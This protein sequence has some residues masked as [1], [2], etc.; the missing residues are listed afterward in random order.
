MYI[1][2]LKKHNNQVSRKKSKSTPLCNCRKKNNCR[3][4]ENCLIDNVICK[5]TVSPTTVTKQRTYFLKES[6][7]SDII[8]PQKLFETQDIKMKHHFQLIYET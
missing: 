1:K 2:Q 6:G 3:M 7:K 4:D 5:C 8:V